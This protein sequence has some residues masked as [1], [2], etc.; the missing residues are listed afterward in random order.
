MPTPTPADGSVHR[1]CA[2][3]GAAV[4]VL[5][6]VGPTAALGATNVMSPA[7]GVGHGQV[8]TSENATATGNTTASNGSASNSSGGGWLDGPI[9]PP[10][11]KKKAAQETLGPVLNFTIS[12]VPTTG[13]HPLQGDITWD[14]FPYDQFGWLSILTMAC[15][16]NLCAVGAFVNT[17]KLASPVHQ[18][19]HQHIRMAIRAFAAII[20]G[21]ASYRLMVSVWYNAV[22]DLARAIAPAPAELTASAGAFL[23]FG[24]L[25]AFAMGSLSQLGW[26]VAKALAISY[27]IGWGLLVVLAL[28]APPFYVGAIYFRG[29]G[30]GQFCSTIVRMHFAL[31]LAPIVQAI[32]VAMAFGL[33]W[34]ANFAGFMAVIMS[35]VLFVLGIFVQPLLLMVAFFSRRRAIS[36]VSMGAMS[37]AGSSIASKMTDK[38]REKKDE[39]VRAAKEGTKNRARAAP[40]KAKGKYR[41]AKYRGDKKYVDTDA[42]PNTER[43]ATAEHVRQS[44]DDS[45]SNPTEQRGSDSS[46]IEQLR[47]Q[48]RRASEIRNQQRAENMNPDH[49]ERRF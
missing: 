8:S 13:A 22:G 30:L 44:S 40:R 27:G 45:G 5:L 17:A 24:A 3:V 18:N 2:L 31:T 28:V 1:A 43:Q 42:G 37:V 34:G 23:K 32:L 46:R 26:D 4:I 6:A 35:L 49:R 29:S 9:I 36:L 48:H 33:D 7:D 15:A 47:E 12:Y 16:I 14:N 20:I 10:D 39:K 41:K 38:V 25:S 11:V 21:I 19:K